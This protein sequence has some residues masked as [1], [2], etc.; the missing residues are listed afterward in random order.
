MY[1]LRR[2]CE[3]LLLLAG[4]IPKVVSVRLGDASVKLTLDTYSHVFPTMQQSAAAKLDAL[5]FR[6]SPGVTTARVRRTA[7]RSHASGT[8]PFA[9]ILGEGLLT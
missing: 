4:D 8:K 3:T 7:R 6:E 5:L 9:R 1:D 2:S